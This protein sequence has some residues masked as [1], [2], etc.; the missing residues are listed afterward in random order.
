MSIFLSI[1]KNSNGSQGIVL[2]YD[3]ILLSRKSGLRVL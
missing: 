2:K 1:P 3:E